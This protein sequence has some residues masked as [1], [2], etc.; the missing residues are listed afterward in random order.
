MIRIE[1][2]NKL[3]RSSELE[4]CRMQVFQV[5]LLCMFVI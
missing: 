4:P 1:E 2:E 3:W 5:A